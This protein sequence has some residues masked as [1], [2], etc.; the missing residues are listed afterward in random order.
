LLTDLQC[1]APP[2]DGK[3]KLFDG[4]GLYLEILKSGARS[5]RWKYRIHGKEKRLTFGLY[6]DVSL[7]KAR[8]A[9]EK[10]A[11]LLR[12]GVDPSIDRVLQA[13]QAAAQGEH[14]FKSVALSWHANQSKL[15]K[16]RH[17]KHVLRTLENDVFPAIG[18]LPIAQVTSPQIVALLRKIEA[19]GSA[20]VAHRARQRISDIFVHA[21]ASAIA[22]NN[23][24]AE[25]GK[26][27][28][29]IRHGHYPAVQTVRVVAA[30]ARVGPRLP[31]GRAQRR[32]GRYRPV[33]RRDLVGRGQLFDVDRARGIQTGDRSRPALA[34]LELGDRLDRA[35]LSAVD[36]LQLH[37]LLDAGQQLGAA[38]AEVRFHHAP[39]GFRHPLRLR[40]DL[41]KRPL[42]FQDQ[43]FEALPLVFGGDDHETSRLVDVG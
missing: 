22:T 17:A 20:D 4:H 27:L 28:S 9:R 33:C 43:V 24:A 13:A 26:A 12:T 39:L 19:R 30:A 23:P 1:K 3:S 5:W 2:I 29:P 38:R 8:I 34:L 15:F 25:M 35:L 31:A 14:T 32:V 10:A 11:A 18:K 16:P 40:A 42:P 37:P 6:P 36:L 7:K 21:I 41:R